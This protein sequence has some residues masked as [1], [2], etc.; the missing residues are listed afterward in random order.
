[1][2]P[3]RRVRR[4]RG[5]GMEFPCGCLPVGSNADVVAVMARIFCA[6][7]EGPDKQTGRV[8]F[9]ST[10][11][12]RLETVLMVLARATA[13]RGFCGGGYAG[14]GLVHDFHLPARA[15]AACI[16]MQWPNRPVAGPGADASVLETVR[17]HHAWV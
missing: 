7:P 14:A 17:E 12:S 15:A 9:W 16:P 6:K 3:V 5:C 13:W 10:G 11:F 1:M 8:E 2:A 4:L